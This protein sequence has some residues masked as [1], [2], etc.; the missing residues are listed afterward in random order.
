MQKPGWAT[1]IGVIMLL[2]GGCGGLDNFGDT[3]A[4]EM[5]Q[6]QEAIL[7]E[8][9]AD[10]SV[11]K[12]SLEQAE[13]LDSNDQKIIKILGDTIVKDSNDNVSVKET[14]RNITRMS[15]YRLEWIKKFGYIG[16]FISLLFIVA[17][18]MFL[19]QRKYTIQVAIL[20]LAI[21]LVVGIFQFIIYR[22]D[23]GTSE[24]MSKVANVE[25]YVS[26][27]IDIVLLI[28]IMV[29]DKSY[30]NEAHFENAD[31]YDGQ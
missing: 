15:D 2:I 21:S 6:K 8:L 31:Y 26:I 5:M 29:L 7:D 1:V 17:G 14:I 12:D 10:I 9:E 4:E 18:I 24:M 27:F 20:V 28:T 13:V 25:I 16:L 11:E 3:K 22:S 19:T 30:Y 23:T